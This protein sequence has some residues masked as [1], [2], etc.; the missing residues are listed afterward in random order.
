MLSSVRRFFSW[1]R[2]FLRS[3][4]FFTVK[5]HFHISS[6]RFLNFLYHDLFRIFSG[7]CGAVT[8][9]LHLSLR[10]LITNALPHITLLQQHTRISRNMYAVLAARHWTRAAEPEATPRPENFYH[11]CLS[12][13]S[14]C[15]S[16]HLSSSDSTLYLTIQILK[17]QWMSA[18]NV[19]D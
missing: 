16:F 15:Q 4:S 11:C 8:R 19:I 9:C 6:R 13:V 2:P 1:P 3:S 17:S 12:Q 18:K 14:C 10:L 7:P 5:L